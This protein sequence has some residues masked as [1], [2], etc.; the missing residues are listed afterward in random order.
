M[1]GDTSASHTADLR[2]T[3]ARALTLT[4]CTLMTLAGYYLQPA[5]FEDNLRLAGLLFVGGVIAL[6]AALRLKTD[7]PAIT[8]SETRSTPA[9]RLNAAPVITGMIGLGITAEAS[10]LRLEIDALRAMSHHLQFALFA[11]SIGLVV[12]G[13]SGANLREVRASR[14]ALRRSLPILAILALAL[15]LRLYDLEYAIHS[16]VDESFF[17]GAVRELNHSPNIRLLRPFNEI[18]SF[19]YLF[20]YFQAHSVSLMGPNLTGL[21]V[22]SAVFG[23]VTVGALYMLA[24]ETF[25]RPTALIAALT[26][27]TFPPH[28]QF[29][30]I[31]LNN[32]AEPL[33]GVLTFAFMARALRTRSLL[34]YVLAGA[35]LGLTQYFYEAGRLLYPAL[36]AGWIVWLA[37]AAR[38][39]LAARGVAVLIITA[40]LVAAPVYYTLAALERPLA[41]R[42]SRARLEDNYW[43]ALFDAGLNSPQFNAHLN[44]VRD[45]LMVYTSKPDR[46]VFFLYY[47]GH[48]PLLLAGVVPLLL[49]G[50]ACV[51]WRHRWIGAL[52]LAWL[53]LASL[54]NSLLKT[55]SGYARF[56]V[57]HPALALLMAIGVR[58]IPA[59]ILP[60]G[61]LIAAGALAAAI[62]IGQTHYYFGPHLETYN[63]QFRQLEPGRDWM[64]ALFRARDLPGGTHAHILS[65][66]YYDAG[67]ANN[68]ISYLS[69]G[70]IDFRPTTRA[71]LLGDDMTGLARDVGQ[72]FFIVP[73]DE[74]LIAALEAHF[75][76]QPLI[77]SPYDVPPEEQ[78]ALFFVPAAEPGP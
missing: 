14:N 27:A 76:P 11:L 26:L 45:A 20:P 53:I 63:Q 25:D 74:A 16:F 39:R 57:T 37:I 66:E 7:S 73:D 10:A 8:V 35:S 78:F 36:T 23:T 49:L 1:T 67:Y 47:G 40:L 71:D 70:R 28:L 31:G 32:I 44:R 54:G 29:S 68:I 22:V 33:F 19:T 13:I 30:R 51:L 48:T 58:H 4:A 69:E 5:R 43:R 34:D 2:R 24:R 12:W 62:A 17:A 42:V 50:V 59:Q 9:N 75:G 65:D 41:N 18:V 46:V 6:G 15:F 38:G 77:F 61:S 72:A 52:L 55:P 60:R 21:R 3:A 56:V 64:D